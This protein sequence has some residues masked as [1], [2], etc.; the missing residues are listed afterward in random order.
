MRVQGVFP[1]TKRS[2]KKA[3]YSFTR[4]LLWLTILLPI[5]WISYREINNYFVEPQAIF[6]LGGATG[7]EDFAAEFAQQHPEL[8]IWIS[9]GS[10]PEYTY[11]I[12]SDAGIN[13]KQIHIDREAVDTVTNFTTLVDK[14]KAKGIHSVYL[15][16]S[17]YHMRRA[18]TIGE[19][20][21]GSRGIY[22]KPIAVHSGQTVEPWQKAVRDGG[23]AILWVTTGYSGST[24]K[25]HFHSH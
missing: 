13:L 19:I 17:D 1:L 14:L 11:G 4:R 5:L 20:I 8:P 10:N 7:R 6:V 3:F 25:Q 12:F 2:P 22:I 21:F 23:R 16:T 24:L 18:K 9:G 15:I